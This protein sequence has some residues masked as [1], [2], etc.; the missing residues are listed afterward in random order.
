MTVAASLR[1]AA[2]I[3]AVAAG[4]LAFAVLGVP[5][6]GTGVA[7]PF[8]R[9][10]LHQPLDALGLTTVALTAGAVGVSALSGRLTRRLGVVSLLVLASV[11]S[12]VALAGVAASPVWAVVVVCFLLLGCGGGLI[13]AVVQAHVVSRHGLRSMSA[14]HAGYGAGVTLGPLL[15]TAL[16]TAGAGWRAGYACMAALYVAVIAACVLTRDAWQPV[17]DGDGDRLRRAA[18]GS[19]AASR[20]VRPPSVGLSLLLFFLVTGMELSAMLWSFT[21]LTGARGIATTA[22]G[23][24]VGG[25]FGVQTLTRIGL[26]TLGH[27]VTAAAVLRACCVAIGAG[28][29]LMLLLPGASSIAGLMVAGSGLGGV[30]PSLMV[31]SSGSLGTRRA[32]SVVGYQVAAANLGAAAGSGLTGVVLARAGVGAFPV[33][34]LAVVAAVAVLVMA[35]PRRASV[36]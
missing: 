29:A 19:D 28:A 23:V 17:S 31:A 18:A 36:H 25:F 32:Q 12:G 10:D 6:G 11:I 24:A 8:M 3:R 7:W 33:V 1:S 26:A 14:L 35:L 4:T 15:V 13:D 21:F 2:A 27:R 34:L 16:L 22:A 20:E 9:A 30:Y 5:D